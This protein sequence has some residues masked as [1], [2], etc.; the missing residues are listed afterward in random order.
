MKKINFVTDILP[1]GIAVAVFLLITIFFFNPV[2]FDNK[3]LEQSDIQ[4]FLGTSKAITDHRAQTGEEALWTNSV[5]SGMPAYLISVQW[6]NHAVVFMKKIL[7]VGL[8][9]PV[10][11]I[12]LAFICYYIL[13]LAF[14]VRPYLA[15]AG[16][17]AFGLST[18][19]IIGLSA[20]HNSR[21]GAIAF[22]PL[23]MAGI[24]LAFSNRRILGLG[25]ATAGLAL[26][27]RENHLQVTYYLLMI[28]GVYGLVR[29]V[30]FIREKRGAEF[31]K[32]VAVLVPAV[33]I[34]AASFFGQFWA[35]TEYTRY[36]IR[37]KDELVR[38]GVKNSDGLGK[39][40]AFAYKYGILEPMTLLIPQ[41]YGGTSGQLLVQDRKSE[42]FK[43]LSQQSNE[44]LVNQLVN[45]TSAYWGP[46]SFASPYYAGA[47]IIFLFAIGIAFAPRRYTVWL[48]T[49]S[50]IGVM[51]A[52]GD[53]LAW[54]NYLM[55]DYFPGYNKFR[56]FSFAL[57]MILFAMPLLGILGVERLW[58][59]ALDK[60][61]KRKMLIAFACTGGLCLLL[62]LFAGIFSFTKEFESQFPEW[63]LN[64]LA[65]DRKGLFRADAF[66]SFAF[67]TAMFILLYFDVHKRISPTGFYAV[68]IIMITIDLSVVN[69]RYLTQDNFK[70]KRDNSFVAMTEAD[71]QILTD[72][73]YYR[74]YN[75]QNPFLEART[76][77]HH[78]SIGG[79]HGAKL[80]R[81]Q[82]FYDSCLIDE[83]REL[84]RDAEQR[85]INF[86]AYGS[87]NMLN[88]KYLVFGPER[89]NII[90]NQHAN[91]PAWFVKT[92][93]QVNSATEELS[94]TCSIDTK[95]TAVIDASKF[96][97]SA[98]GYDS[99]ATITLKEQQP[100]Q[101][102]YESSSR[103]GGLVV[104]SE[105]YYPEGWKATI[106]GNEASI[107][108]ANYILRALEVPAGN[109]AIEFRFE[110]KA[111]TVGNKVSM[112]SSWLALLI[113][114]GSIGWSL[115]RREIETRK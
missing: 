115:K 74:V 58:Q 28:V 34:A 43:A 16:A 67:I 7:S 108:R 26:H 110:P 29:L 59:T 61:A 37:G 66:R 17:I 114:L 86:P 89:S 12:Y 94:K 104:F 102:K 68:L 84:Y 23:V 73:S 3:S 79:Y 31:L 105:I 19:M 11:N 88:V 97:I 2:F 96:T 39:E 36:S 92:I 87:I 5:F 24:H 6:G 38:P 100:N 106:D 50:V 45:Y 76:S 113:L 77:Y 41:F 93:E 81:Y 9:H 99:T 107:I 21:I 98:P 109:H 64:A 33:L 112:A 42:V 25:V 1:H 70:R 32:N 63:F 44:Q 103:S 27:L 48:V 82:D 69:N 20:G 53:S 46:Q 83:T 60:K 101:L 91:G 95:S 80:R 10:C 13:L 111:Y 72:K 4:Q 22:M 18:Y 47:I 65:D 51:L 49:I 15:I 40:Y 62:L 56:S 14:R 90:L 57:V 78:H 8:P 75:L 55:F 71:Q 52:W 30:E 35:I 85:K 54:F